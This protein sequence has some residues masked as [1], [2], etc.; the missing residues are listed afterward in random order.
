MVVVMLRIVN[1]HQ[2]KKSF[3]TIFKKE[4]SKNDVKSSFLDFVVEIIA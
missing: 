3:Y 4:E 2:N 1:D